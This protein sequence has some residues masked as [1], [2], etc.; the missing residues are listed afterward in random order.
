MPRSTDEG[1]QAGA[2]PVEVQSQPQVTN[3]SVAFHY[4]QTDSFVALLQELGT[5]L[6][7]STYQ[8][9]KLIA[10]RASGKG[11]STLVR[12]FDRPM[13]LAVDERRM[14]I[15]IRKEVWF[16]R[17]SPD[18]A[19]QIEPI[20]THDACYLPRSSH[21]TG[22]IGVH[23]IAWIG[24][25]LWLVNTRFSCLC[26]L[27]PDYSFVPRWKPPFIT[28][29]A[30]EDRCHLN[31]LALVNGQPGFVTA[32]GTSDIRD[33]WR[34]EKSHGGCVIDVA[35]GE[36]VTHGLSM[37]H[38]PRWCDGRLWVL[39]SG[40]G[41]L[42]SVDQDTGRNEKALLLPGF[43]R[44]MAIHGQYAFIG[45]SKI[46]PTSAMDGV[47]LAQR[48]QELKCGIAAVDLRSCRMVALLEFQTAV[49]E[50]FDVQLLRGIC[51]PE[52]VGFQKETI[53][54]TF[55]LPSP[56]IGPG[57]TRSPRTMS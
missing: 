19:P 48:R 17:N 8:A 52:I 23:E 54:H 42:V 27:A 22:D 31:G 45:L 13:G 56:E 11:L 10:V 28:S 40:T 14:A 25:A 9:N 7:V 5:S 50:I 16:L 44:G 51:F 53:F 57:D 35:S 49:E 36:L 39:E 55:A 18:L 1:C 29:L 33:G 32:L 41:S 43:A 47:P 6:L 15:G 26:T 12:T 24:D 20:G 4:T 2:L 21:V 38:S 3:H 30:A 46:R 34:A 37:P